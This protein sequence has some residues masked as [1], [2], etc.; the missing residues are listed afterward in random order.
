[1]VKTQVNIDYDIVLF[2]SSSKIQIRTHGRNVRISI[3]PVWKRS[4]DTPQT[5]IKP[6]QTNP[7]RHLTTPNHHQSF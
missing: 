6:P 5:S 1:M 4:I 2:F 3:V 7:N